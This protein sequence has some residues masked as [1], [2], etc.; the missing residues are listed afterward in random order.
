MS[1]RTLRALHA[2][3][4]ADPEFVELCKMLYGDVVDPDTV[5]Q[6]VFK[7]AMTVS[8]KVADQA[9][10]VLDSSMELVGGFLTPTGG[11][12]RIKTAGQPTTAA[13]KVGRA[14]HA[15]IEHKKTTAG[16]IG[17]AV[18]GNKKGKSKG[19]REG[20]EA[21]T[22]GKA[23]PDVEW[24]GT[25]S[26]LDD[27]KRQAFGFASVVKKNGVPVIDR[28]GD[29]VTP[30]DMENAAYVYVRKSRVGGDMHKRTH[31][32]QPHHVSDLIESVVFT[33]EKCRAMGMPEEVA[34]SLEGHWWVGYQIHDEDVWQEV[35]KSG[36]TGFSIH[37][38]GKREDTSVDKINGYR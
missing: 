16:V 13:H 32:D 25:F 30:D 29:Y 38:R 28:Q 7:G 10:G 3:A 26:K 20:Y 33:P 37:G 11:K 35:K 24:A 21:A 27:D 2:L 15:P 8:P 6:D 4:E 19:R 1:N 9:K 17:A 36:R 14:L 12:H 5:Y 34:K 22:Y 31:D 23:A 18:V